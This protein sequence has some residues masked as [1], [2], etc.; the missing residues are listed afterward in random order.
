MGLYDI[1]ESKET[2][3]CDLLGHE[4]V[5]HSPPSQ[6]IIERIKTTVDQGSPVAREIKWKSTL[7]KGQHS[8]V[9]IADIEVERPGALTDERKRTQSCKTE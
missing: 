6:A 5:Q 2:S 1:L 3:V 4:H 9:S 8:R 7:G